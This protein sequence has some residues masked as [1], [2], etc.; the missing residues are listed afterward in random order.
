[1]GELEGKLDDIMKKT[2]TIRSQLMGVLIDTVIVSMVL[3]ITTLVVYRH[4]EKEYEQSTEQILLLNSYNALE[5]IN[6]DVY[7]YTLE[8]NEDVYKQIAE[9]C[10]SNQRKLKQ[11]ADIHAGKQFYRDVRDVEQM[12]LLYI[13]RIKKIYD[14]SYLCEEMT[15]GSKAIIN[16][17]YNKTQEVYKAMDAQFQNLYSE[18]LEAVDYRK[19]LVDGRFDCSDHICI[20]KAGSEYFCT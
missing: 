1:M 6:G 5:D 8:G 12:F 15:I 3:V 2:K 14:H 10:S 16:K 9:K 13:Q 11:L 18:L 20:F 17:Y 7:T 4:V 19:F